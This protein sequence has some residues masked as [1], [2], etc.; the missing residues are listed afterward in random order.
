MIKSQDVREEIKKYKYE[1]QQKVSKIYSK[2]NVY[3]YKND[4][5][6]NALRTDRDDISNIKTYKKYEKIFD[7]NNNIEKFGTYNSV[8]MINF[9]GIKNKY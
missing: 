9:Q 6:N 4:Y 8:K 7:Q 5:G 2:I 3:E 1:I